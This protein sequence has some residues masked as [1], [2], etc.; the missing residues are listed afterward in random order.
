M[1]DSV[2]LLNDQLGKEEGQNE[3]LREEVK[4]MQDKEVQYR[5]MLDDHEE[6]YRQKCEDLQ[7]QLKV[8][9]EEMKNRNFVG[10]NSAD[11]WNMNL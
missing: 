11:S 4:K 10:G 2:M 1:I 7:E 8:L 3:K 6:K 9:E 5:E